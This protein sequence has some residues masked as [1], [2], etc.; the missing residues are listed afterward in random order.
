MATQTAARI[1]PRTEQTRPTPVQ[2]RWLVR[3][4]D[5]A[6]GKLPLFDEDGREIDP[7]TIKSCIR[8]GW[9]EPWIANPIKPDWLV[10]RLT[11]AGREILGGA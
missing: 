7:R 5:Q 8:Q 10:C 11:D 6:G 2:K 9:A 4:L 1:E 3:G